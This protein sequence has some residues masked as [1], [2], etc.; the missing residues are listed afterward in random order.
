MTRRY[1][2]TLKQPQADQHATART[3][4]LVLLFSCVCKYCPGIFHFQSCSVCIGSIH[5]T[6]LRQLKAFAVMDMMTPHDGC[7]LK[8]P[9][10]IE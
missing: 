6:C 7:E 9:I 8:H 5:G 4:L 2:A 10:S 1:S 3:H